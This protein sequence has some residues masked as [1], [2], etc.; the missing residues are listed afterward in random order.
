VDGLAAA[1]F[2]SSSWFLFSLRPRACCNRLAA[3]N[4]GGKDERRKGLSFSMEHRKRL[5]ARTGGRQATCTLFLGE[6]ACE[7]ILN[8]VGAY[9][10]GGRRSII[11][12]NNKNSRAVSSERRI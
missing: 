1:Y 12:C 2:S 11:T 8:A 4:K 6:K 5:I 10:E 7:G 3:G 9:R